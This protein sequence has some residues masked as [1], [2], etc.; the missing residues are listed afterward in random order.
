[1]KSEVMQRLLAKLDIQ[2]IQRFYIISLNQQS[3]ATGMFRFEKGFY[4]I[5]NLPL[6]L[7]NKFANNISALIQIEMGLIILNSINLS[8]LK[9]ILHRNLASFPE[10]LNLF[11]QI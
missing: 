4:T 1:M 3:A 6:L 10:Q 11:K 2:E 9:L 5:T 8:N 7:H